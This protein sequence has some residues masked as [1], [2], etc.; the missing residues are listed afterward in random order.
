MQT[1]EESQ[2]VPWPISQFPA[3]AAITAGLELRVFRI[4]VAFD[5][6]QM[7]NDIGKAEFAF[8]IAPVKLLRWNAGDDL[9]RALA[10]LLIVVKE[11]ARTGDFHNSYLLHTLDHLPELGVPKFFQPVGSQTAEFSKTILV[12]RSKVK[13]GL[14]L[15]ALFQCQRHSLQQ[16][17]AVIN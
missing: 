7:A 8:G 11:F 15:H 12:N 5:R 10:H 4:H 3:V 14:A 1:V 2:N 13:A 9:Q 16:I 6:R 17:L